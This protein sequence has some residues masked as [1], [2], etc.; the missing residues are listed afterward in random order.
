MRIRLKN[1][2]PPPRALS[3]TSTC[4]MWV[5]GSRWVEADFHADGIGDVGEVAGVAGDDGG[6]VTDRGGDHDR[7]GDIGGARGGAG[8]P[9]GPA[10]ALVV[11]DDV[12]GFEDPGDLVLGAAAPG[13]GQHDDR[14]NGADPRGGEFV[15]ED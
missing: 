10:D 1:P 11:G 13:L 3:L 12:A 2:A 6:L 15:M 14:H 4:R 7:V 8:Y 5:I 9:G